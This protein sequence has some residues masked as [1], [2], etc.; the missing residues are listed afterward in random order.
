MYNRFVRPHLDYCVEVWRPYL[1]KDRPIDL[2]ENGQKR[3]TKI[4][5]ALKD[6]SYEER[7]A[8]L[9]L[10]TL[11]TRRI[12]GDLIEIFKILKGID[13]IAVDKFF[14]YNE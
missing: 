12:G 8:A 5:P 4:V 3:A 14:F 6:K 1:L 13:N 9:C 11:E 7:L 10:T 2:L